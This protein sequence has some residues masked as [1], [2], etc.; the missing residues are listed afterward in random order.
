MCGNVYRFLVKLLQYVFCFNFDSATDIC[1]LKIIKDVA[2][3]KHLLTATAQQY[4]KKARDAQTV[5]N[6]RQSYRHA[7]P[8]AQDGSIVSFQPLVSDGAPTNTSNAE[9]SKGPNIAVG[10]KSASAASPR[11][12]SV[13]ATSRG[14]NGKKSQNVAAAD[15]RSSPYKKQINGCLQNRQPN[16]ISRVNGYEAGRISGCS[17]NDLCA[18]VQTL[19]VSDEM[20]NNNDYF[21][22]SNQRNMSRKRTTSGMASVAFVTSGL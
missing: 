14:L 8:Q 2:D 12:T 10:L 18:S 16:G 4:N 11:K 22:E 6:A 7:S 1:D 13:K 21:A 5:A 9:S 17:P 15:S 3:S 19:T 20:V